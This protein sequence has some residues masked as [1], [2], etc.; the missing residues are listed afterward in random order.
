MKKLLTTGFILSLPFFATLAL[1]HYGYIVLAEQ[2][3]PSKDTFE[4]LEE[5]FNLQKKKLE[6]GLKELKEKIDNGVKINESNKK[7]F[8]S[9]VSRTEKFVGVS[10]GKLDT[11]DREIE[12]LRRE[13]TELK[14]SISTYEKRIELLHNEKQRYE[15]EELQ[16]GE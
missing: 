4:Q 11:K 13:I 7:K 12:N 14:S 16:T 5:D 6:K 10:N 9:Y 8:D 1:M 15:E 2:R 3:C